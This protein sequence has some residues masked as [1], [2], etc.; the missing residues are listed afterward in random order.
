MCN[1]EWQF[2]ARWSMSHPVLLLTQCVSGIIWQQCWIRYYFLCTVCLLFCFSC[3]QICSITVHS[4]VI[5]FWVCMST[6]L[7]FPCLAVVAT[8]LNLILVIVWC[9][10]IY[11]RAQSF[12]VCKMTKSALQFQQPCMVGWLLANC[13]FNISKLLFLAHIAVYGNF[14]K[15]KQE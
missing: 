1:T 11:V 13:T 14:S 5:S 4:F 6:S 10:C 8:K 7:S 15:E 3:V 2:H 12:L 9:R